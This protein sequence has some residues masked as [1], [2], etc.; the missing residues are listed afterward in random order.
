MTD[1]G[2]T[3][4]NPNRTRVDV[5]ATPATVREEYQVVNSP[6]TIDAMVA[7]GKLHWVIA[8][9]LKE[10]LFVSDIP[11]PAKRFMSWVNESNPGRDLGPALLVARTVTETPWRTTSAEEQATYDDGRRPN[12]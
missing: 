8:D 11:G 9:R 7:D 2:T 1:D 12:G 10:P 6:D 5:I 3:V 4:A